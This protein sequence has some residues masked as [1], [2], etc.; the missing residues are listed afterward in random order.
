MRN[1]TPYRTRLQPSLILA[2]G[3]AAA[4]ATGAAQAGQRS[5][6]TESNG[7]QNCARA[8]ADLADVI[9]LDSD[10]FIYEHAD[11]RRFYLNGRAFLGGENQPI[12]IACDTTPSGSRVLDVSLDQGSYAARM[13]DAV[14]VAANP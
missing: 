9:R 1:T 13:S 7:Y 2:A 11:A 5:S 10:Y 6:F 12:R 8:A 14:N 4:L 3:V